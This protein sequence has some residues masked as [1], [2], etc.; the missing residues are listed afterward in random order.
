MASQKQRFIIANIPD[1]GFQP[2][3][4]AW[5]IRILDQGHQY[6]T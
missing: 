2:H 4:A 5:P 3:H 1:D 6:T